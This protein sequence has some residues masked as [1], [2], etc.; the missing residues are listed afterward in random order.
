MFFGL[1]REGNSILIC[2]AK[3]R[4]RKSFSL[5]CVYILANVPCSCKYLQSRTVSAVSAA[6][7]VNIWTGFVYS[8]CTNKYKSTAGILR[9]DQLSCRPSPLVCHSLS[10]TPHPTKT[11]YPV[12]LHHFS[13]FPRDH[14]NLNPLHHPMSSHH[15]EKISSTYPSSPRHAN[16]TRKVNLPDDDG[17]TSEI[18]VYFTVLGKSISRSTPRPPS[19]CCQVVNPLSRGFRVLETGFLYSGYL[20][21]LSRGK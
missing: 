17:K 18:V 16:P 9:S 14:D 3:S 4:G 13:K 5:F 11:A 19:S 12:H 1:R 8:S 2:D 20:S 15:P 6:V 10:V 21:S 7:S